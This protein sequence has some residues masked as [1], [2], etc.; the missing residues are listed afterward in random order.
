VI[1]WAVAAGAS[2]GSSGRYLVDSALSRRLHDAM[3]YGTL[4]VNLSGSAALGALTALGA[5]GTIG[6]VL[7]ALLGIGFCGAF[8]TFS[9]F[10][11]E[12][13]ALAGDGRRVAAVTYL[14]GTL[15]LGVAVA[16]AAFELVGGA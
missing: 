16:Y 10:V 6:P 9:T 7:L 5:R 15:V 14:L 12:T 8:T 1:W 3:P 2:V 4:A 13:V 11:W